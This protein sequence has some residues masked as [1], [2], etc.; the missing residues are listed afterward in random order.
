[1]KSLG[2][3]L[4]L[5]CCLAVLSGCDAATGGNGSPLSNVQ[6]TVK[7]S[8]PG[9]GT[10]ISNPSGITC[11]SGT[12][13]ARFPAGTAVTLSAE[14]SGNSRFVKWDAACSGSEQTCQLTL[15][16]DQSVAAEFTKEKKGGGDI[17]AIN[18]IIFMLQENRSMDHYFGHLPDYWQ[19]HNYPQ[20]TNGTHFDA[21]PL[22]ASNPTADG[23][24]SI[25]AFHLN[26]MCLENPSPSWNESHSDWNLR[27]VYS[28][29][30][31]MNGFVH[32]AA[33]QTNQ[34]GPLKGQ[35]YFDKAGA[36][37]MG[38]YNGEDLN[39]Y[40]FMASNFGTSDRWFAP[41]MSRTQPNR[42]F[43]MAGTSAGHVYPI[44]PVG[45]KPLPNKTIFEA[46]DQHNISWKVYVTDYVGGNPNSPENYLTMFSYYYRNPAVRSK[47]VPVAEYKLDVANG[48]LPQV[49]MIEG[50]YSSGSDEHPCG[51]DT[52]PSG[53]VQGGAT[54]VSS[55][56][57]ALM[58]SP[59]WKDSVF[60]LSW[61]EGGGFYDHVPPFKT[62]S[63]D[64]V[65]PLDLR[66]TDIC[67]RP[68]GSLNPSP[69]CDFKYTGFRVPLIVVSPF[70]KK[71]YVSNTPADYTAILKLIETRFGLDPLTKRDA[72][73][74]DMTEFFDFEKMP[75]ETPPA[76][77]AQVRFPGRCYLNHLP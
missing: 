76:P 55:L 20:L 53:N 3:L 33:G 45:G 43:L 24:S 13:S 37:V 70:S 40:Y 62:V 72:A 38:Y 56:I 77:P 5:S 27:D 63:P 10:I 71:N 52:A 73:Q 47:V 57:N 49:A 28:T 74:P 69:V 34:A 65:K 68:D 44:P 14:P 16:T 66:P 46:L 54:Y 60:I 31:E 59:S 23:S 36:R 75:W 6:L 2:T 19:A 22:H 67:M 32:T 50:G 11:T 51:D 7:V 17:S 18:H 35:P 8:G 25:T 21:E 4:L 61:D 29:N 12:C 15:T 26:A 9:K 48:T 58:Q 1:M 39:Y 64:N 30:P 42:M 41:V